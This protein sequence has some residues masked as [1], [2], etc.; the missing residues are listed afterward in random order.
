MAR[1]SG[2]VKL[3]IYSTF[4][5][6][7]TKQAERAMAQFTKKFG[8]VDAATGK[9]KLDAATQKLAEQSIELDQAS[10]KWGEYAAKFE[11]VG[12]A[13][14]KYVSGPAAALAGASIA[15]A[16]Q[17]DTSFAK[18]KTIMDPSEMGFDDMST[19][20]LDLSTAS[21]RS[22]SELAEAAY[23]AMSASVDTSKA[24]DFTSK[25]VDLSKAGFTD[26]ATAVDTLTTIIKA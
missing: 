25:A 11:A 2:S 24:V 21:G 6:K 18:V 23:Q 8:E 12:T 10:Q 14:T 1:G 7:G 19:G 3:S 15:V 13:I 22:A 5:D 16:D 9:V 20:L 4:D 26:T 17:W